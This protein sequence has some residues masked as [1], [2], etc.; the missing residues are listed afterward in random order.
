MSAK[1]RYLVFIAMITMSLFG[2]SKTNKQD[3]AKIIHV[4]TLNPTDIQQR[5]G[6]SGGMISF[7]G[8]VTAINAYGVCWSKIPNPTIADNKT[9]D[10]LNPDHYNSL[11][12]GLTA[13]TTYYVKAYATIDAGTVYGNE[14][15]FNSLK[16]ALP[17]VSFT[18]VNT[19]TQTTAQADYAISSDGGADIISR[20]ICW[21]K[22]PNPTISGSKTNVVSSGTGG[23][24]D[25]LNNL[26]ENTIYYAR[27]YA[28]NSVGTAYGNELSFVTSISGISLNLITRIGSVI[29]NV[30]STV[31]IGILLPVSELSSVLSYGVCWSTLPNPSIAGNHSFS[32]DIAEYKINPPPGQRRGSGSPTTTDLVFHSAVTSLQTGTTYYCRVFVTTAAGT[33]YG[34]T[35]SFVAQ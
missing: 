24:S 20:G 19:I 10:T 12:T 17:S 28:T 23:F 21:S 7:T 11:L 5:V 1:T 35:N 31:V 30:D 18:D 33:G 29:P 26:T 3:P 4:V 15:S 8:A 13:N 25:A 34:Q 14:F 16:L 22:D 32:T 6:L 2:C 9:V 27:S